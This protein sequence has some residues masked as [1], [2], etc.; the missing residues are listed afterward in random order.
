MLTES[1]LLALLGGAA[2]A[3]LAYVTVP[4][5]AAMIPRSLPLASTPTLDIRAFGIAAILSGLTGLG[6]GLIP[7][8]RVGGR[9]G[10]AALR[11]GTRGSARR[12]GVR[13]AL[14]AIEV[15]VSV[16]LLVASGLLIRAVWRVQRVDTGFDASNVL[17]M[18]TSLPLPKYNDAALRVGFYERVLGDVRALPGVESAAY[19]SGVPLRMWGGMTRISI[20][21]RDIPRD[22]QGAS[23]RVVSSQLFQT[24]KVPIRSGRDFGAGDTRDAQPVAIVSESFAKRY[25]PNGDAIGQ[26]FLTRGLPFTVVGVVGD[27]KFRGLERPSEPQMYIP[28]AQD[29][30]GGI[31]TPKDLVIRTTH[32]VERTTQDAA[33]IAS[34]R[35]IIRRA[36]AQQPISN[37]RMLADVVG[38]QTETRRSQ[39]R[40]LVL[41]A[42]LA[43]LLAAVG[44]HG[45]L[46]FTVA[47]RDREIGV[48]LALGAEPSVVARMVVGEGV[49]LALIG[50]VPG[51]V[52]AYLAARSMQAMLFG[53]PAADPVTFSVVA[54]LCFGTVVIACVRPAWRASRIH[55]IAALKAD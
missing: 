36:D 32:D 1:V 11:E 50:V 53:V 37:I 48:R 51:I 23:I 41:L 17:T 33:L 54:L 5:L 19:T 31:Y 45:L 2:G 3:F 25:W 20:K 24:F 10:L 12:K 35:D 47:Q 7:A 49:R 22:E 14:V 6:F 8:M 28:V 4:L 52:I 13:A 18:E 34:V 26:P 30:L 27:I 38:D 15:S 16:I 9:T 39:A 29:S 40:I 44:I 42:A 55:P 21:G 46:A 43:L